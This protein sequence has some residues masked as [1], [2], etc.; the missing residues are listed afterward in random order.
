MVSNYSECNFI[1][2]TKYILKRSF[3]HP[4]DKPKRMVTTTFPAVVKRASNNNF[5]AAT[6]DVI[7]STSFARVSLTSLSR[8]SSSV[9]KSVSFSLSSASLS[10]SDSC[11]KKKKYEKHRLISHILPRVMEVCQYMSIAGP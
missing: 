3:I 1:K 5:I 7:F 2:T 4:P 9:E 10:V 11:W 8:V 6:K